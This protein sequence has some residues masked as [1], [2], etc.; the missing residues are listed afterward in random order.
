MLGGCG[1]GVLQDDELRKGVRMWALIFVG[2]GITALVS[3]FLACS[4][5]EGA[6]HHLTNKVQRC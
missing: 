4:G 6:G 5:F 2:I 1:A 3:F